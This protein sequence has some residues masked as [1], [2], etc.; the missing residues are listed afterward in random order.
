MWIALLRLS[1]FIIYQ[2]FPFSLFAD[3]PFI[4]SPFIDYILHPL[5]TKY[6]NDSSLGGSVVCKDNIPLNPSGMN[7]SHRKLPKY[8]HLKLLSLLSEK[9]V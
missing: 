8:F 5:S 9:F 7:S 2:R 3:S 6:A 1:T 4:D